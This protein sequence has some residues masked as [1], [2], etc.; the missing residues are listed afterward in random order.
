MMMKIKPQI[1]HVTAESICSFT[2]ESPPCARGRTGVSDED[3]ACP[4]FPHSLMEKRH[5]NN[6]QG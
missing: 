2:G 5:T 6:L 1:E 4:Y 3:K